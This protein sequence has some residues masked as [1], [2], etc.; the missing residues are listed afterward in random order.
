MIENEQPEFCHYNED[1][2]CC[3]PID[4][5]DNCPAHPDNFDPYW[6]LTVAEVK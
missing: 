5:C 6:G 2:P 3:Y 4:D 1:S